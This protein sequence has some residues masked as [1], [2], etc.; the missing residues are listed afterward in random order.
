MVGRVNATMR[1]LMMSLFPLGA[2]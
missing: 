1:F 2:L